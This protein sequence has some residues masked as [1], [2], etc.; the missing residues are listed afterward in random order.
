MKSNCRFNLVA[1][2][3]AWAESE[4]K[5][6]EDTW[7]A[8]TF[9]LSTRRWRDFTSAHLEDSELPV[10]KIQLSPNQDNYYREA[11]G[12]PLEE[13]EI[14]QPLVQN[15]KVLE[16]LQRVEYK[17]FWGE[18]SYHPWYPVNREVLEVWWYTIDSPF[19]L[20]FV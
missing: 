10:K 6:T 14:P 1:F 13:P 5:E 8:R 16:S 7:F 12:P 18:P 17:K 15:E 20:V 2:C 3:V 11:I 19:R 4:E 9:P